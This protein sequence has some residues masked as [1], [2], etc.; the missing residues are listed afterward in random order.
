MSHRTACGWSQ[1]PI[2]SGPVQPCGPVPFAVTLTAFQTQL[3][4]APLAVCTP[5][6]VVIR[7][8][9][10]TIIELELELD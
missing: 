8:S 10:L 5:P 4:Y 6:I 9:G 2:D 3:H 1:V 7:E